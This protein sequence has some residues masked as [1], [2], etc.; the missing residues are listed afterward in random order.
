VWVVPSLL[1]NRFEVSLLMAYEVKP[2]GYIPPSCSRRS[3]SS[4]GNAPLCSPQQ[5]AEGR[6]R[7]MILSKETG[8]KLL[9]D[10]IL[11][12][13]ILPASLVPQGK[14]TTM[15]AVP[16]VLMREPCVRAPPSLGGR[17]SIDLLKDDA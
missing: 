16:M 3:L 12:G 2:S 10:R 17:E 13:T 15:M 7:A 14:P 6:S 8:A 9:D 11:G 5:V 4:K 1:G